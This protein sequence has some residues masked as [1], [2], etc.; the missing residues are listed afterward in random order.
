MAMNEGNEEKGRRERRGK[1]SQERGKGE[2]ERGEN[3]G[4][5]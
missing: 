2:E 5:G 1:E 4:R 3:I